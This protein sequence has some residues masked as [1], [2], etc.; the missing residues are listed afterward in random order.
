MAGRPLGRLVWLVFEILVVGFSV[1]F[2]IADSALTLTKKV[3]SSLTLSLSPYV[4]VG[5]GGRGNCVCWQ[6]FI[7]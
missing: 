6:L 5:L 2:L 3:Q 1:S 7:T 4:F